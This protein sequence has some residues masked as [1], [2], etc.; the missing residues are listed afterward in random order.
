MKRFATVLCLATLITGTAVAAPPGGGQ[1]QQRP[2]QDQQRP[3]GP[4]MK[5]LAQ[6]LGLNEDQTARLKTILEKHR[7]EMQAM[8]QAGGQRGED[9]MQQRHAQRDKHREELLTV[10]SYEQL[11]K[12]EKFMEQNRPRGGMGDRGPGMG[13]GP[14]MQRPSSQP[15]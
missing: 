9:A 11:Y 12:F 1:N 8:R 14:G 4:D 2:D 10:L 13:G 7:Q 6:Q 3:K 5:A 15:E